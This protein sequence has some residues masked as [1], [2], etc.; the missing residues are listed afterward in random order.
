MNETYK[1]NRKNFQFSIYIYLILIYN[2]FKTIKY[3]CTNS[4]I[5]KNT[6]REENNI[7]VEIRSN[8]HEK[9]IC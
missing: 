1:Y 8:M 7:N 9:E 4:N 5:E 3:Y 2:R 6:K